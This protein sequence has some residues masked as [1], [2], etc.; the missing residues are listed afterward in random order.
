MEDFLNKLH[1]FSFNIEFNDSNIYRLNLELR[2]K[3]LT[4]H[5]LTISREININSDE[6]TTQ[7][8]IIKQHILNNISERIKIEHADE[9]E[10]I[11]ILFAKINKY[12]TTKTKHDD[13]NFNIIK[14]V[15]E[16]ELEGE[17]AKYNKFKV[18]T[19]RL[20]KNNNNIDISYNIKYIVCGSYNN[21]TT[22]LINKINNMYK[23][24][25]KF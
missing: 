11:N 22:T 5:F 4:E 7:I 21:Q 8:N 9:K 20:S 1:N 24:E 14:K 25:T 10:I 16:T 23:N 18:I 15:I 2:L 3:L 17:I 19:I 13:N 12:L 6:T